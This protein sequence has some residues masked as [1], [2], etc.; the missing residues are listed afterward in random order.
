MDCA[1]GYYCNFKHTDPDRGA[2]AR[3]SDFVYFD[4]PCYKITSVLERDE[5]VE[6]ILRECDDCFYVSYTGEIWRKFAARGADK[7]NALG[8]I[9][10]YY[11]IDVSETVAF[12]DDCNDLEMLSVAG[13]AVAMGNAIDKVK[14]ISDVITDT[15]DNDGIAILLTRL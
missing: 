3:Y 2:T 10:D 5:W 4:A 11:G 1:D 14:A 7:G 8:I 13:T 12:G 15:N 6:Q 9:C